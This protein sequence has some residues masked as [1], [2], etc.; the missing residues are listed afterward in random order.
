MS[1]RSLDKAFMNNSACLV[2][3]FA[4]RSNV[5]A[6]VGMTCKFRTDIY[7]LLMTCNDFNDPATSSLGG[8]FFFDKPP[9]QFLEEDNSALA[10]SYVFRHP[11]PFSCSWWCWCRT[12]MLE[13]CYPRRSRFSLHH[14]HPTERSGARLTPMTVFLGA[15]G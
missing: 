14:L 11:R 13:F 6:A 1:D 4:P 15:G 8:D 5:S 7:D 2:K 9:S 3:H 12:E 10:A